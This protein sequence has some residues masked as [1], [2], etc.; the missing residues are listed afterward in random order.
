[1][2]GVVVAVSR[3]ESYSFSKPPRDEVVL[4]A[5]LGVAGDSHAGVNVRH[6]GRVR[7]DPSQPNL[8]QVHLIHA[9]LFEELRDRGWGVEPGQLGENVTTRGVDLLGLPRGTVLR[10]VPRSGPGGGWPTLRRPSF[11][12]LDVVGESPVAGHPGAARAAGDPGGALAIGDPSGSRTAREAVEG[13][14]AAAGGAS[15]NP[16]AASAVRALVAAADRAEPGGTAVVVT[17]LRNPCRQINTFRPGLL[18][19][20]V[21]HDAEGNVV[22]KGGV[23]AVVLY[24]GSVRPGDTVRVELPPTPHEP[25]ECV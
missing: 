1:M 12:G 4:V 10:F 22:R 17:G 18:K 2:E 21:G 11:E 9:E 23:M 19:E 20:V 7:A 15:L 13:V 8:R 6:Q 25:L 16:A 24:G 14:L 5:G 3:N